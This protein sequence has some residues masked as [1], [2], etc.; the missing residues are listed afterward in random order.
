MADRTDE[1]PAKKSTRAKKAVARTR[2]TTAAKAKRH[3]QEDVATSRQAS[4]PE[5]VEYKYI[6]ADDY[7]P[8][9]ANGAVGGPGTR[10]E[11]AINFFVE[12][13]AVPRSHVQSLIPIEQDSNTFRSLS[14]RFAK[15]PNMIIRSSSATSRRVS[16]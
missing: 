2:K 10:G 15:L 11:I 1:S 5:V 7:N 16:C 14:G 8:V 6:F 12:R 13:P 3:G 9:Y 4:P